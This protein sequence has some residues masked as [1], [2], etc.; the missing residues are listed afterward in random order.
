VAKTNKKKKNLTFNFLNRF[1][2]IQFVLMLALSLFITKK[3]SDSAKT[4]ATEHLSAIANE[5]ALIVTEFL[6]QA[7]SKLRLLLRTRMSES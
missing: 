3:V 1:M 2:I 7:E 6:S 4:N 5:R